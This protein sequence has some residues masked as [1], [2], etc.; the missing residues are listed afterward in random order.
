[1]VDYPAAIVHSSFTPETM[2]SN[3]VGTGFM[4]PESLEVGVKGVL[5]RNEDHDWWGYAA[6]KGGYIDRIEYIDYGTDPSAFV[7][8]YEAD[9]IDMNWESVG[10]YADIYDSLG[11]TRSA[12]TAG[13]TIV[14]RTNQSHAQYQDKRVRQALAM[15]V[16]N[17]V[18]LELGVNGQGITSG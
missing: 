8:A 13:A 9:E 14:V 2:M 12:V 18:C 10:D 11:L 4:K 15:A 16:D 1:M 6:G 7:A 17:N 5:V 3:P